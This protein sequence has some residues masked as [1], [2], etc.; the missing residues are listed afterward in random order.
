M[1]RIA[2]ALTFMVLVLVVGATSG[3]DRPALPGLPTPSPRIVTDAA[4]SVEALA[5]IVALAFLMFG[6]PGTR[7]GGTDAED[8]DP[9]RSPWWARTLTVLLQVG[10]G[11]LVARAL[12]RAALGQGGSKPPA[13]AA[14]P[15][16][17]GTG[18]SG[19]RGGGHLDLWVVALVVSLAVLGGLAL[20]WLDRRRA[21]RRP[22][23]GGDGAVG[24]TVLQAVDRSLAALEAE[25]D[26]RRAVIAA[27]ARMEQWLAA[28]GHGRLASETPYEYLDRLMGEAGAMA[29]GGRELTALFERARFSTHPIG[30]ELKERALGA[31]QSM[32]AALERA[33]PGQGWSE[34]RQAGSAQPEPV[35]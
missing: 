29:T 16:T 6:L 5:V 25:P 7:H 2:A 26:G 3:A 19:V 11:L 13:G 34:A 18:V 32:R 8:T 28:A 15:V 1:P 14:P 12:A 33:G 22:R 10:A 31:L 24:D 30:P 23:V 27:Y 9:R 17:S 4:A 35:T 20:W 21:A